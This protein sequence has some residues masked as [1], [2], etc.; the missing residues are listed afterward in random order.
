MKIYTNA[1]SFNLYNE[2]ISSIS[3]SQREYYYLNGYK[4][5]FHRKPFKSLITFK[6]RIHLVIYQHQ[7]VLG[8]L[9]ECGLDLSKFFRHR[10]YLR[11]C[12]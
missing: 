1:S 7:V 2:T 8:L 11:I 6:V 3:S 4:K 10:C 9:M 5:G 12:I